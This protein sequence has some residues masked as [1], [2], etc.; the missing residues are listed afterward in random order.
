MTRRS[1]IPTLTAL[2]ALTLAAAPA[3]AAGPVQV[4]ADL[5]PTE[6]V[7]G[8]SATLSITVA[9]DAAPPDVDAGPAYALAEVGRAQSMSVVNGRTSVQATY[10][11]RVTPSQAGQVMVGP[12]RVEGTTIPPIPLTVRPRTAG[13]APAPDEPDEPA[14]ADADEP[15]DSDADPDTAPAAAAPRAPARAFLRISGPTGALRLGETAPIT[16]RAYFLA[17]TEVTVTGPPDLDLDGFTVSGLDT[18]PQ[19]AEA[20]IRGNRY[21]VATWRGTLTAVKAGTFPIA[22]TLPVELAWR[23]AGAPSRRAPA[24]ARRGGGSPFDDPFFRDAFPGGS[25]LDDPLVQQMLSGQGLGGFGG[26]DDLMGGGFMGGGFGPARHASRT[27]HAKLADP[28]EVAD[29]PAE[30]RPAGFGGAVG[31]F[32]LDATAAPGEVHVGEPVTV[33]VRVTGEG[34]FD[35]VDVT[36]PEG[37]GYKTYPTASRFEPAR[38]GGDR[39]GTKVFEQMVVPTEPGKLTLPPLS[40]AYFDPDAGAYRTATSSPLTLDVAPGTGGAAPV[41]AA[42]PAD[43]GRDGVAASPPSLL[44]APSPL[45][46]GV[47]LGA[48]AL[49]GVIGVLLLARRRR[50]AAPATAGKPGRVSRETLAT[51][52]TAERAGDAPAFFAAA[53]RAI[54]EKLGALWQLPP[55]RVDLRELDR[56]LGVVPTDVVA[57]FEAADRLRLLPRTAP[58]GPLAA[59]RARVD[60]ALATL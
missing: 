8:E 15:A 3:L 56:R 48:L 20:T 40:L 45:A 21:L 29:V 38:R 39:A 47:G 11:W 6:I 23:D 50:G 16:V 26:L 33:T 44:S 54:A 31:R 10:T 7:L 32:E 51:L 24:P 42:P 30:G 37:A 9:G 60:H 25:L 53:R 49:A 14:D 19:Q 27:L 57:V 17:G 46:V 36:V 52:A 41:A 1:L 13:V 34:R 5:D 59:W 18:K 28:V 55:E 2:C 22:G 12:T 43:G 4:S 58:P 35:A